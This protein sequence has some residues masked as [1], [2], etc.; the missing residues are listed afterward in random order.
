MTTPSQDT[1]RPGKLAQLAGVS[2]DTLRHY[3]RKGVLPAPDRSDNGYRLYPA[4]ALDRVRLI[5]RALA[6]GFTLDELAVILR[7][8]DHGGVPCG[9][10]RQLAANKL[11]ELEARL[12]EIQSLRDTLSV[13]LQEWDARLVET[14]PGQQ[15]HLLEMLAETDTGPCP[16]SAFGRPSKNRV[17]QGNQR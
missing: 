13:L 12:Q 9:R 11:A 14:E 6:V 16:H 1:Y 17:N 15:A 4:Q 5:R 7:E 3:E 10:V 8:R 2:T